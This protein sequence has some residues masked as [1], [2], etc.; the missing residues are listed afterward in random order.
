MTLLKLRTAII[1]DFV[2]ELQAQTVKAS[3][4][5]LNL[6]EIM[7]KS[8]RA[9]AVFVGCLKVSKVEN[10]TMTASFAAY[11]V[12]LPKAAQAGDDQAL[13]LTYQ[14]IARLGKMDIEDAQ[15]PKS[16]RADNLYS[17][18]LK[19]G[20][21]SLWVV[22]WQQSIEMPVMDQNAYLSLS[23]FKNFHSSFDIEPFTPENHE[24]WANENYTNPPDLED[25]IDKIF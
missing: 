19:K 9:P 22:T 8:F 4:G 7:K 13:D 6:E 15:A 2:A 11:I 14:V 25:A 24:A 21:I 3:Q 23:D 17:G 16:I 18:K 1:E 10:E 20:Q 12:S 5:K